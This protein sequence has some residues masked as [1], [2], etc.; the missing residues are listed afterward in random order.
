MGREVRMVPPDWQHPKNSKG[1]HVP[2]LKMSPGQY[3]A[4]AAAWAARDLS[5]LPS[6]A[7]LKTIEELTYE[8][9]AGERCPEDRMPDFEPGTATHLMLYEN[10]T[11][12]TPISPAFSTPEALAHWLTD[13]RASSF[14]SETAT[15]EQWLAVAKG[16]WAPSMVMTGGQLM[17]GVAFASLPPAKDRS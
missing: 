3:D 1:H 10:T 2:L 5:R 13:N 11:E 4:E 9:W 12:G 8:Q 15:Y 16:G 7:D 17:S 6:Y 14:G